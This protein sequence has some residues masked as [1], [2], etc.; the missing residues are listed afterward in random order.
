M[1]GGPMYTAKHAFAQKF[2]KKGKTIGAVI[3]FLFAV[4]A[5]L[6]SFGIGNLAQANSISTA[7]NTTFS[8]PTWVTGLVIAA[9]TLFVLVGGVQR[10]AKVSGVLV[11]FMAVFYVICGIVVI[12]LNYANLPAGIAMIFKMAFS[13]KAVGGGLA[14]TITAS[15]MQSM[16]WGVARGVFS[17]EAGMG[18][19]AIT[20]AAADT[21]NHVKQGYINMCGTFLDTIVVCTITGLAIASSGVLGTCDS[22]GKYI[23]GVNLTIAAFQTVLGKFGGY[24]ISLGLV[25]FAYSTILGWEYHGEKA[26]EYLLK[27]D[28]YNKIYRVL[29]SCITFV[30]ATRSLELVWS[31]SDIANGLMIIPNVI[32]MLILSREI[33]RDVIEYQPEF[34]MLNAA[35]KAAAKK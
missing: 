6:A 15:L 1:A 16:K 31:F 11:P 32:I 35:K 20:A 12:V 27:K 14:G 30:G 8:V 25:L 28:I 26:L 21:D 18:S 9:L 13:V 4:F 19:A 10:I 24:I 17:N 22:S 7:I 34:K 5:V 29:F 3:G 2:G 33:C 23:T